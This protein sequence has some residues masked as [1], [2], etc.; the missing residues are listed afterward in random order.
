M[1]T[2]IENCLGNE[3]ERQFNRSSQALLVAVDIVP[4]ILALVA[5]KKDFSSV[6]GQSKDVVRAL[7]KLN[8]VLL[9]HQCGS[10]RK[11]SHMI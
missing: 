2:E 5:L 11:H 10:A 1:K 6:I 7:L 3:M 9:F 4:I 8:F